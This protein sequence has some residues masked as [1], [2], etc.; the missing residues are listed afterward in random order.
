MLESKEFAGVSQE[1]R[2]GHIQ[3]LNSTAIVGSRT[4]DLYVFDP[5][6]TAGV[7]SSN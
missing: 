2:M 1:P 6:A 3:A 5:A 4:L 7:S